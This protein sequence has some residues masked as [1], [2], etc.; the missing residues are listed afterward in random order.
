LNVWLAPA[1]SVI[2]P[3]TVILRSLG[4]FTLNFHV[5]LDERTL[6]I[7]RCTVTI[8]GMSGMNRLG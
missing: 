2:G 3:G 7:V 6:F 1:A 5:P 4:A 8:P